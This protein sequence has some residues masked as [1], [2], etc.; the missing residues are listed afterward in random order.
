MTTKIALIGSAPSS[1]QLAPYGDSSWAIWSC[2]PGAWPHIKRCDAH[3]ELHRWEKAPWFSAEYIEFMRTV[4]R[5]VLMIEPVPEIQNSVAYP[6]DAMLDRFGPWFFTSTLSWMFALA[7]EKGAT[8][9]G[10]WG[11]DM[12]AEEEWAFQRSGCHYFIDLARRRGIKV[13]VPPESDLLQPPPLYGFREVDPMHIKLL[14]RKAE[15]TQRLQNVITQV[16][17]LDAEHKHLIGAL[18][19]C[20]YMLKTWISDPAATRLAYANPDPFLEE[21]SVPLPKA[22][23]HVTEQSNG[24]QAEA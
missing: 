17:Q 4:P 19:N 23:G 6:K 15:L 21:I 8:E 2:S 9:I 11:V 12:S 18:G 24:V 3:F 5:T 10:L 13:T 1:V 14:T 22:N 16:Q 20:E 7:I